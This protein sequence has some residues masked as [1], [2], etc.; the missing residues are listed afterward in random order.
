MFD[1][2]NWQLNFWIDTFDQF[3]IPPHESVDRDLIHF[4]PDFLDIH[5][6]Y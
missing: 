3:S 1:K 4:D 2:S 5:W 6:V